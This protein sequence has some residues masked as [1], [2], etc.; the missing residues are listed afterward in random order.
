MVRAFLIGGAAASLLAFASPASAAGLRGA[1]HQLQPQSYLPAPSTSQPSPTPA[2][3]T[4]TPSDD[5]DD[6]AVDTNLS[7]VPVL[8]GVRQL[9]PA[10]NLPAEIAVQPSNNNCAIT[11][12]E[13]RLFF[14]WRTAETH[15]ASVNAEMYIVSSAD[16]GQTWEFETIIDLD[17]DIREP[18]FLS[19]N[20]RLMFSFFEAGTNPVAFEPRRKWRL[21]WNEVGSWTGHYLWSDTR[22]V[23][24]DMKVRGGRA[25]ATAY[26]GEHYTSQGYGNVD[27]FLR[28]SDDGVQWEDYDPARRVI[29]NGGV[30][31]VA[32]EFDAQGNLWGVTR[33]EDGD[34]SGFGSHV[35][36][37]PAGDL[38]NWEFP[39]SSNPERYD[40]P[41][42][43]RHGEELYLVARRDVGGPFD[44][45]L[46]GL[47]FDNQRILNWVAY[48]LRPKRT[49]LYR[50]NQAT[51]AVE[52]LFDLPSAGDTSFPSLHRTG[53][54][55]FLLVNYTSPVSQSNWSWLQGQLSPEGTSVYLAEIVFEA[56]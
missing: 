49:A 38:A 33:N 44:Q 53:P 2:P 17:R 25:W 32:F 8:R 34:A 21:W 52:H 10:T 50:I 51:R 12:H 46:T 19:F 3:S 43:F 20:G 23:L 27:V 35:V 4:H 14:A 16:L 5:P 1:A 28:Y 39:A 37:A 55:S 7:W 42:M 13:G 54:H 15:F 41:K 9:V 6:Y 26:A 56:R 29:Y 18:G 22:E 24:W 48:S 36:Y 31:E 30:S 11:F 45:Q 40:S 47:P